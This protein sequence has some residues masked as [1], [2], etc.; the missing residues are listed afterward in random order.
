M[1]YE[2]AEA[3][4]GAAALSGAVAVAPAPEPAY[5]CAPLARRTAPE[6]GVA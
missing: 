5:G 4:S 3:L 1:T 2:N 6:E